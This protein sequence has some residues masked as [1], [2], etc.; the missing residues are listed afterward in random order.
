MLT[1]EIS[2]LTILILAFILFDFLLNYI[3]DSMNAKSWDNSIPIELASIYDEEKYSKARSYN[4]AKGKLSNIENIFGTVLIFCFLY[5]KVFAIIHLQISNYTQNQFLQTLLFFGL[6]L[7]VL[8]IVSF[9]FEIY[10]IFIIEEKFGFNKMTWKTLI[11]DKVK[12]FILGI[13]IGGGLLSL[14]V[15]IYN[16]AGDNFWI[17][18]WLSFAVI[19]ILLPM[20]YTSLIVPIFNKLLP[21]E[22]GALRDA[23]EKFGNKVKFPLSNIFV[24]DGSKRS[25]K[26][27]AFFSGVGRKKSIVFYD[28]LIKEQSDDELVSILAHEVGHY[29]KKHILKSLV[30]SLLQ[31]GFMLY[32]L[33]LFIK[34][35][36]LTNA[37][38]LQTE[39]AVL[40]LG[41]MAFVLLYSPISMFASIGINI[42]SRKNEYEADNYA[43]ENIGTS[44]HLIS[45]L[46]KLSAHNLSN[47]NPNKWYVFFH[48]SHPTLLER[49]QKLKE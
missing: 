36:S 16:I 37:L 12:G 26:A 11:L 25:T 3:L 48:Y 40:H 38:G 32:L 17:Y 14:F 46:K 47:L 22:T 8:S 27:N 18:T 43:K 1:N 21:L 35:P 41:L 9:P 20:F 15:W 19:I 2:T 34:N 44:E 30:V 42:L 39:I 31:M 29:K 7:I 24:I 6:Y 33:S 23:I 28:T 49:I 45:S 4:I 5:F 13:I 10:N